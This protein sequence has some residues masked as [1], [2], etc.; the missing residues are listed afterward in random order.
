MRKKG[1]TLIETLISLCILAVVAI[2][3][4][5]LFV[6]SMQSANET[7]NYAKALYL[8]ESKMEELRSKNFSEINSSSFDSGNGQ[9]VVSP[10]TYDLL[11][12]HLSYNW[13]KNRKPIEFYSMRSKY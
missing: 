3:F 13:M 7:E 11:E 1:F 10:V 4:S 12:I 2:S 9:T 8:A 6:S 5:Y